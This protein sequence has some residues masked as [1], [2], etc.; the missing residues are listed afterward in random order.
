MDFFCTRY[1]VFLYSPQF[2]QVR[3][4]AAD[5]VASYAGIGIG[6]TTL[7]RATPYRLVH[8]EIPIP[9]DLIRPNFPYRKLFGE[10][11]TLGEPEETEWNEAVEQMAAIAN[12]HLQQAREIQSQVPRAARSVLLP[13][14][15]SLFFM[16]RFNA[17]QR[18]LL[19]PAL[20]EPKHQYLMLRL[21]KSW[22]FGSV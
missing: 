4:D 14:V 3:D 2:F 15:P 16:E 7:L 10:E 22:L 20:L 11:N 5:E 17:A 13:M 18:N 19:D 21:A 6:L 8:D 9:A 12:A 1:A